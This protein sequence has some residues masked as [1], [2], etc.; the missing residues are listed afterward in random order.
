MY[1]RPETRWAAAAFLV[2]LA[3]SP[4][5]AA[6]QDAGGADVKVAWNNGVD[7]TTADGANELQLGGLIQADGRFSLDDPQ[8]LVEDTFVMRRVRLIVQGRLAKYFEFRIMPDFGNGATVLYDAF[9]DVRL[10]PAFRVRV[11]KDK[12]PLGLEQLYSDYALLFPERSLASNLVPNRDV[13]VQAQGRVAGVLD[14]VAGVLNGVP[15]A[16]LRRIERMRGRDTAVGCGFSGE[17]ERARDFPRRVGGVGGRVDAGDRLLRLDVFAEAADRLVVSATG[18]GALLYANTAVKFV[19]T[20]ER[21]V[22]D[23]NQPGSRSVE[24]A[25]V[26]RAQLNL[27]PSL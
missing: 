10:S 20:Y 14:Y 9:F 2:L 12:T 19:L 8:H 24:H 5:H 13:G 4:R 3:S 15:D 25:L 17:H 11:G 16:V 22:F 21:T 1:R 23:D 27:Q 6:A 7:V 18:V 26:F